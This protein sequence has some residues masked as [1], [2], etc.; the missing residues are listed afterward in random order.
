MRIGT[1]ANRTTETRVPPR[2]CYRYTAQV[3][4]STRLGTTSVKVP[5]L[6]SSN[7]SRRSRGS[8]PSLYEAHKSSFNGP[9]QARYK[10]VTGR[11]YHGHGR[12]WLTQRTPSWSTRPEI[13]NF[14]G[15]V[16]LTPIAVDGSFASR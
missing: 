3:H 12:T 14:I 15:C 7:T 4:C 8:P 11:A 13:A 16:S 10:K 6:M 5:T 9:D 1:G 2:V